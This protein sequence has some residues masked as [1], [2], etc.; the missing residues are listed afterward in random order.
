MDYK[1]LDK[2]DE[3]EKRLQFVRVSVYCVCQQADGR[4]E[5]RLF[6]GKIF[7]G[8]GRKF[9]TLLRSLQS[10]LRSFNFS[11]II[12]FLHTFIPIKQIL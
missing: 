9:L 10:A 1:S 4:G 3:R 5:R 12:T 8:D 6:L 7:S 11:V 2:N